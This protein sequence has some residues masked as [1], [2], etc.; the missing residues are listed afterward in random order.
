MANYSHG[1]ER[2]G[3]Q[4][5]NNHTLNLRTAD[6]TEEQVSRAIVRTLE[7]IK[8]NCG[9]ITSPFYLNFVRRFDRETKALEPTGICFVFFKNPQVYHIILGRNPD[10]TDRVKLVPDPDWVAPDSEDEIPIAFGSGMGWGDMMSEIEERER[11]KEQPM[12]RVPLEPLVGDMIA[13][14][15]EGEYVIGIQASFEKITSEKRNQYNLS[16][17]FASVKCVIPD[18]KLLAFLK[19]FSQSGAYPKIKSG[20]PKNGVRN[21]YVEFN[22]NTHDAMFCLQLIKTIQL[23]GD[24]GAYHLTRFEY[25]R[26]RN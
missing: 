24:D 12:I 5:F 18:N 23:R 6:L 11:A 8:K 3:I 13:M 1:A 7:E 19:L 9:G 25:A 17:L 14:T 21:V 26:A 20:K 15:P 16:T 10:G 2:D 4:V 22:P